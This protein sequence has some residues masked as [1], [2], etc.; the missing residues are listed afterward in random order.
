[1]HQ[2]V[3]LLY[4]KLS[5]NKC[6]CFYFSGFLHL[7]QVLF[8]TSFKEVYV[9]YQL[10]ILLE[11]LL[12]LLIIDSAI[13]FLVHL[14]ENSFE[15]VLV[16]FDVVSREHTV[17]SNE[18]THYLDKVLEVKVSVSVLIQERKR[19]VVFFFFSAVDHGVHYG[20]KMKEIDEPV[21]VGI[22]H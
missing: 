11:S 12:V 9:L 21:S 4:K 6:T 7:Q 3:N 14:L 13:F 2:L 1:M 10:W 22:R 18:P 17:V 16:Y 20:Q 15:P 5:V 8:Y 19:E